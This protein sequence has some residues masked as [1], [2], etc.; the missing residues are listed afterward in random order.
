[1]L[2]RTLLLLVLLVSTTVF[3]AGA[4]FGKSALNAEG[5]DVVFTPQTVP[6]DPQIVG[7]GVSAE[8]LLQKALDQLGNRDACWLK[9]KI[10]QTGQGAEG[11]FVATGW[12]QRGP[13]NCARLEMEVKVGKATGR[14]VIVSDGAVLAEVRTLPGTPPDATIEKLPLVPLAKEKFLFDKGCGGPVALVRHLRQHLRDGTLQTGLLN[15][16]PVIRIHG[17]IATAAAPARLR[18]TAT[19]LPIILYLDAATL[20]PHR[21]EWGRA[22]QLAVDFHDAHLGEPLSLD[23]CASAF[24]YQPNGAERVTER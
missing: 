6:L 23:E 2:T 5:G 24:S 4:W 14:L 1:M 17:D 12:L 22:G 3:V 13:E 19:T 8:Q 15:D 10:R 18:G 21:C 11:R 9:T 16:V 20:W 7:S